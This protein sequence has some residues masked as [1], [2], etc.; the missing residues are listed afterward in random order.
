MMQ[1]PQIKLMLILAFSKV[2]GGTLTGA[3]YFKTTSQVI[4]D[5]ALN[6]KTATAYFGTRDPKILY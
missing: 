6:V 4:L 2:S 5:E 1:M 3:L